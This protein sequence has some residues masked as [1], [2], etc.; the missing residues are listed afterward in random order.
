[1][2]NRN[3]KWQ[4]T[5]ICNEMQSYQI[6]LTSIIVAPQ[7]ILSI[8]LN[9]EMVEIL[10]SYKYKYRLILMLWYMSMVSNSLSCGPANP[11]VFSNAQYII[12]IGIA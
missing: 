1:M 2:C 6:E 10:N 5:D 8:F 3:Y 12:S 7:I 11:V 4:D 9:V